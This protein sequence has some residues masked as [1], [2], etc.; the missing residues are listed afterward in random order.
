MPSTPV[1][2]TAA[3]LGF[4]FQQSGTFPPGPNE[5][6]GVN[7]SGFSFTGVL[8]GAEITGTLSHTRRI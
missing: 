5:V 8:N 2:G 1:S 6:G 3:N 7:T 4:T